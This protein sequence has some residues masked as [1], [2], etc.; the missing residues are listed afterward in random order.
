[1]LEHVKND[2]MN[3]F[4]NT[5]PLHIHTY[6]H[7]YIY[8]EQVIHIDS[9]YIFLVTFLRISMLQINAMDAYINKVLMIDCY[10]ETFFI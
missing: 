7:I 4:Q 3:L 1:M 2:T 6:I 5:L 10:F 8:V 9:I